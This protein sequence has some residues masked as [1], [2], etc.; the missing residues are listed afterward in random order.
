MTHRLTTYFAVAGTL[1]MASSA[2]MAQGP[3]VYADPYG[4]GP[5][6]YGSYDG[7]PP[8]APGY[9]GGGYYGGTHSIYGG[10]SGDLFSYEGPN[11]GAMEHSDR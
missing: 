5:G 1:A 8:Y 6:T 2:S 4:V 3:G 7:G 9:Y 10:P 11:R